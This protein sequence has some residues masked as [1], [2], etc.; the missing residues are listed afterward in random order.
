MAMK[1]MTLCEAASPG[2]LHLR[3][4]DLPA[5]LTKLDAHPPA[6]LRPLE[7]PLLKQQASVANGPENHFGHF[8]PPQQH[9]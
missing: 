6:P 8:N 9:H 2:L 3:S 7:P 4:K 5:P 1:E